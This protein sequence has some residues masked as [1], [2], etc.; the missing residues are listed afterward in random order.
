[1]PLCFQELPEAGIDPSSHGSKVDAA[2]LKHLYE[3][4]H[5]NK[6]I[7]FID[8]ILGET[9]EEISQVFTD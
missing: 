4:R 5:M 7:I 6:R 3:L 9:Y 8:R 1:V 2:L